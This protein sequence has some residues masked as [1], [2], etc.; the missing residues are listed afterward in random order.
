MTTLKHIR[1][2]LK[3]VRYG[4]LSSVPQKGYDP[5]FPTM[6]SP[7]ARR[8][9]YAFVWPFIE[10]FLLGKD[11]FDAR[12]MKWARDDKGQLI[13]E[14]HPKLK[15]LV[16]DRMLFYN[17]EGVMTAAIH[18]DPV[19]FEY[20]GPLWHHLEVKPS[21]VIKRHGGWVLS[22]HKSYLA[23]LRREIG[24]NEALRK[25]EGYKA[26]RDRLEVFIEMV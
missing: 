11:E 12:R 3:F 8:G 25:R 6:H 22:D 20:H 1:N 21:E 4:G 16:T 15:E 17:R 14:K 19:T 7:P 5:S 24:R 13:D 26:T 10:F 9:I 18:K 2:K 23:A